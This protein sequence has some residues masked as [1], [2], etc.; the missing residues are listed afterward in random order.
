MSNKEQKKERKMSERGNK[1]SNVTDKLL[2][3]CLLAVSQTGEVT[4]AWK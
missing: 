4:G 2:V 1:T 3:L